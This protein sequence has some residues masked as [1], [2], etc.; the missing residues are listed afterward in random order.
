M[1]S[2]VCPEYGLSSMCD[3]PEW[4]QSEISPQNTNLCLVTPWL[5]SGTSRWSSLFDFN[6]CTWK[7]WKNISIRVWLCL[8]HN[9]FSVLTKKRWKILGQNSPRRMRWPDISLARNNWLKVALRSATRRDLPS[10]LLLFYYQFIAHILCQCSIFTA[11]TTWFMQHNMKKN[12]V[13]IFLSKFKY[14]SGYMQYYCTHI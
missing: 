12:S 8:I 5:A 14:H 3:S 13:K 10:I 2:C 11:N 6:L 9:S 1:R 4:T 7:V